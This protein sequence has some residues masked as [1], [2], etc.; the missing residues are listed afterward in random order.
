MNQ[1]KL[2]IN[3]AALADCDALE[4]DINDLAGIIED[5]YKEVLKLDESVWKAKEKEKIDQT[6]VPYLKRY[7][8]N[9]PSYLRLRLQFARDAIEAH[10]QADIENAKL[11]DING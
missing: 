10:H 1:N 3:S 6:F 4:K 2:N 7:N 9:Y 8:D 11:E 5:A